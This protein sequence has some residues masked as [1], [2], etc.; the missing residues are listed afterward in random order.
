MNKRLIVVLLLIVPLLADA[1]FRRKRY[2]YEL[3][4]NVGADNFLGDL[5][6]ANQV[7]THFVKDLNF[8]V[9]RPVVGFGV[10]YKTNRYWAAMVNLTYAQL[11]GDDKLTQEPYRQNRNLN[12]K[13]PLL[14]LSGRFE[15]YF[16]QDRGGHLY[17]LKNVHG[18]KRKDIQ[19]YFFGGIGAFW[20]DPKGKYTD[21]K[22][23]SL[24]PLS[25]EGEGMPGGPRKYSP[26]S[27]CIPLG[28]GAKYG[29]DQKWGVG[30]EY[31]VRYTF[32]DYIDDVSGVYYD[33]S[34]ILAAKG[35]I[36]AYFANPSLHAY[37]AGVDHYPGANQ[38]ATGQER[39]N[40]KYKD[41][42]MFITL[43]VNYKIPY[44]RRTRSKF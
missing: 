15:G 27:M 20:F 16:T 7:G 2:K 36:A 33:N 42:Y 32:T 19:A 21:G 43:N 44:K 23:Y 26:V 6:G 11:N 34:A 5:G 25:T 28:L 1:Q 8:S 24:R 17:R 40:P 31:G 12:F 3:V 30:I 4:L 38:T 29:I 39:G 10:R 14:E 13:S 41:A 9:T 18:M 22:W 37:P 35:P